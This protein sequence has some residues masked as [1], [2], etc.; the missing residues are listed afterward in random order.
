M[1][2]P[3]KR[4]IIIEAVDGPLRELTIR[5][6][7]TPLDAGSCEVGFFLSYELASVSLDFLL[8]AALETVF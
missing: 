7:F 1:H 8:G 3:A 6:T 2:P 5:W 4:R